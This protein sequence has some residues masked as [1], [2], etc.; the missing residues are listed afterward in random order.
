VHGLVRDRFS[1]WPVQEALK[2]LTQLGLVTTE[3]VG[4]AGVHSINEAHVAV[5]PLRMLLSPL[6]SA[7]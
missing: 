1:L 2:D 3:T 7:T 6:A 5:E 4:R